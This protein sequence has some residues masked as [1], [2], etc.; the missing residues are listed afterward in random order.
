MDES[1]AKKNTV[2]VSER[3]KDREQEGESSM[4]TRKDSGTEQQTV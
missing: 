4:A 2:W 3:E 1:L